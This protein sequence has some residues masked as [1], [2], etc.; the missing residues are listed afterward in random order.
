VSDEVVR[1]IRLAIEEVRARV[2]RFTLEYRDL[3]N[4]ASVSGQWTSEGE[5]ANARLAVQDPDVMA[6]IGTLNS[7]AARVSMPILNYADLLMVSPANTAV[8]LTKPGLGIPGEPDV[9]Q[10]SGRLNYM[11]VV[12]AD[13]LQGPLAADWA[14][15][16][17]VRRVFVIDDAGIYGQ[18]VASL[19]ADRCREKG[20]EVLAHVSIDPQAAEFKSFVGSVMTADPDLVYFGG[21]AR[22]KGG[23]LARDLV[24]AESEAILL[25]SDGCRTK[26]FLDAAGATSLE[27]RCFATSAGLSPQQSDCSE[28]TFLR[29]YQQKYGT[30][31]SNAAIHGYEA[32]RLAIR[33]IADV[34]RKDRR[35]IVESAFASRVDDGVLGAWS[36]DANGDTTLQ[37][38]SVSVVRNGTF[39]HEEVVPAA[40]IGKKNVSR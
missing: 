2:G 16:R 25:V 7:G 5:A 13:D 18:G 9:Y 36:I 40:G 29:R 4:S 11:R 37:E 21:S 15:G 39:E 8:G 28:I 23:Q 27:G 3:D 30:C 31:P 14:F 22:T 12:P 33:A 6:Y 32:A 19:F 38:V 17:G 1:G 24:S 34:G 10:P 35:A 26:A 20:M